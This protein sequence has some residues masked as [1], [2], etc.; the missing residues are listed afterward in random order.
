MSLVTEAKL[1]WL[2][3]EFFT[4][5]FIIF[6]GT[7]DNIEQRYFTNYKVKLYLQR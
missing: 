2:Q 1:R 3:S 6:Q 5:T 4:Y 7:D